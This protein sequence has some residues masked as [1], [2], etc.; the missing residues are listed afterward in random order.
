MQVK[1]MTVKDKDGNTITQEF[2]IP[3]MLDPNAQ[4]PQQPAVPYEQLNAQQQMDYNASQ[5][6]SETRMFNEAMRYMAENP[7]V[8]Q[9]QSV[10]QPQEVPKM[11]DEF[12]LGELPGE[13]AMTTADLASE[14]AIDSIPQTVPGPGAPP[15]TAVES[16]TGD[17]VQA[18]P[19]GTLKKVVD[20]TSDDVSTDESNKIN[21]IPDD[22]QKS[23]GEKVSKE[24]PGF[25]D[26]VLTSLG[27]AFDNLL[28]E[29]Q[30]AEAAIM[31]L[32]SRA[33]GYS[34][35]G[36][37]NWTAKRYLGQQLEHKNNVQQLHLEGKHT[38]D[39]IEKYKE[40]RD[41]KDLEPIKVNTTKIDRTNPTI[42]QVKGSD[43]QIKLYVAENDNGDKI[44]VDG[45]G[46][47]IDTDKIETDPFKVKGSK[48]Y[49]ERLYKSRDAAAGQLKSLQKQFGTFGEGQDK[50]TFTD[51]NPDTAASQVGKWAVESGID[52]NEVGVLTAQA[53]E[54]M[55]N[56]AQASGK[57]PR[58][59]TPFLNQLVIR[60]R[61]GSADLFEAKGSTEDNPQWVSADKLANINNK[62]SDVMK[63]AGA[64]GNVNDIANIYYTKKIQKWNDLTNE[65][66]QAYTNM[67]NDNESG[68]YVFIADQLGIDHRIQK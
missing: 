67:A 22:Q 39:S 19:E 49:N 32:G 50:G 54:D 63:Q 35:G 27:N 16:G 66:R 10:P 12:G 34:H 47:P 46:N 18:T 20:V 21:E 44:F 30:L 7:Q 45:K 52:P 36:S 60:N 43:T 9:P 1:K 41:T 58:D 15:V 65:Q 64:D 37:L 24:N 13:T 61:V 6:V 59:I 62:I 5:P 68:F 31:Y 2:D 26:K 57:R 14:A 3:P 53:Y 51:L 42:G 23:E 29:D 17:I 55:R 25:F 33:L 56:Y 40:T 4:V 38:K 8:P 48:Q 28:N 11:V